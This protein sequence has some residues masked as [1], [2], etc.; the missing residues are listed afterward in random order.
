MFALALFPGSGAAAP[1]AA[2]C[3]LVPAFLSFHYV[4]NPIR[5]QPGFRG[6]R[7]LAL[8]AVCVTVPIGAAI[9][10]AGAQ[11]YLPVGPATAFHADVVRGCDNAAPFGSPS[12]GA[13]TWSVSD[14]R[15]SI[16]LIGDSNAGQF[17]EP[18]VAAGNKAGYQVEVATYSDCPFVH[19]RVVWRAASSCSEFNRI[20]LENLVKAH[21]NLVVI[22]ARSDVYVDGSEA[23]LGLVDRSQLSSAPVEKARLWTEGIRDEVLALNRAEIPVIVVLPIPVLPVNGQACAVIL[24]L[25]NSCSDSLARPVVDARLA[26]ATVAESDALGGLRDASTLD[27]ESRLCSQTTC[28]SR[29]PGSRL[30]S[31]RDSDHLSVG[32]SKQ[33]ASAFYAAIVRHAREG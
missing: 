21:P 33:L 17:T 3:S 1:I 14:A 16:V 22:A 13:C 11:Q 23:K 4:E 31:Y 32:G 5:L 30:I 25:A 18:V 28:F 24:L 29:P 9:V 20:S 7:R 15:G 2:L 19:L 27:F 6:P 12:R 10:L 8:V 26:A